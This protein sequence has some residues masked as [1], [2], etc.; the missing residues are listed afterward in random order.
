MVFK[1][2]ARFLG[3]LRLRFSYDKF[4]RSKLRGIA[5]GII[6]SLIYKAAASCGE[7]TP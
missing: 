5:N 7:H 1:S 3:L 6:H 2:A 4:P